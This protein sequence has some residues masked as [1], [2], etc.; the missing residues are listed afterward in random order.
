MSALHPKAD[1]RPPLLHVR[2]GPQADGLG[3]WLLSS[4]SAN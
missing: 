3:K 1:I 4:D 2:F